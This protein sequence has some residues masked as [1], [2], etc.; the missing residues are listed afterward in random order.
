M[1]SNAIPLLVAGALGGLV[2]GLLILRTR[3]PSTGSISAIELTA[4]G[5]D[6][7]TSVI[8]GSLFSLFLSGAADSIIGPGLDILHV[9]EASKV[10]T[11][12]FLAGIG[13]ISIGGY[14]FDLFNARAKL[15]GGNP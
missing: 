13:G 2:R 7:A 15:K 8:I 12:G 4:I 1:F 9:D 14:V 11:S 6:V 10:T 5:I 3:W